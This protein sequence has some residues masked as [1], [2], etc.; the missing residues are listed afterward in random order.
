VSPLK[1]VV[2]GTVASD[3]YAGMAL[4]HMQIA[5]GLMRLGHD[6][7]YMETTSS[8]PY[9]PIRARHVGDSDYALPYLERVVGRF[10]LA[11]R[12]AYRRSYGDKRWFGPARAQ[13][14]E[15][16]RHADAVI[17]VSGATRLAEEG[18]KVGNLVY[19]GTDPGEHEVRYFNGDPKI[20]ALIAEHD[21]FATYGETIGTEHSP[22]PPLPGLRARTRQPI[23]LDLWE[24]GPPDKSEFTTVLNWKSTGAVEYLGEKY[25]WTK[26]LQFMKYI[27]LPR[28]IDQ[29]IELAMGE[30]AADTKAMLKSQGWCVADALAMTVDPWPYRNYIRASR[31]EFSVAKDQYVRLRG[32]WFSERSACYLASGRPVVAQNTGFGTVL[33]TGEGLFTF[34]TMDEILMAF[35]EIRSDYPRHGRAARA[36]AEEY[37]RAETVL[38]KLL[39]DIGL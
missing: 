30:V 31:G 6:A 26:D 20:V 37:F 5:A 13:A 29:P 14:V 11:D 16:L 39:R 12:W 19:L 21:V 35:E 1:L 15:L 32:G 8:W 10:G 38:S 34:D 22:I 23:L 7:Y 36:I 33:P 17:N 28:R 27:D 24:A 3:P 4:M 25:Y 2:L 9:D 18:L